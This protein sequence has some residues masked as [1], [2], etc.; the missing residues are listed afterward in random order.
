MKYALII[1]STLFLSCASQ[2]KEEKKKDY[3]VAP[4]CVVNAIT[5][6]T[7]CGQAIVDV[8]SVYRLQKDQAIIIVNKDG[9]LFITTYQ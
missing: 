4:M 6:E 5:N 3:V 9:K 7:T 2:P 1:F 8:E